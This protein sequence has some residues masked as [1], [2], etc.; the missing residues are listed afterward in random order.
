MRTVT[1][2]AACSLDGFIAGP[3]G[4]MD[5][6]DFSKDAQ[7]IMG[8]YWKTIDT[9]LLGRLTYEHAVKSG[10]GSGEGF[11]GVVTYLF[12]RT[13]TASPDPAVQLIREDAAGVVRR[14]KEQSGKDICVMSG[15][16]LAKS[17]FE[18]GVI[19]VV[20]LNIHPVLLGSGTPLFLDPGRRMDLELDECRRLQGGCVYL[21]YRVAS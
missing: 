18:A 1:Y 10:R 19:D 2:G 11:P 9:I 15:G 3:N 5:W 6:L 12:S 14:L 16:A 17:F 13:M 20:G 21:T 7:S 4:E 8:E